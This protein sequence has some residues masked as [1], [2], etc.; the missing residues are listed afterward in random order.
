MIGLKISHI[1]VISVVHYLGTYRCSGLAYGH[2]FNI[3]I[4]YQNSP[5]IPE[6]QHEHLLDYEKTV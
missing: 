6:T 5:C 1:Q 2:P 4:T 3:T